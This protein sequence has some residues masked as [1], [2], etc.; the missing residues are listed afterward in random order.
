MHKILFIISIIYSFIGLSQEVFP[1][2]DN[3]GYMR[4]F[5][6]GKAVQIEYLAPR[7]VKYSEKIIAFIDNKRDFFVFDGEEKEFLASIVNGYDIGYNL[8]AW[9]TG[10]ILSVWDSGK[11]KEL[12][13]FGRHY[14]VTD[15]LVVFEDLRDNAIRVYYKDSIYDLFYSVD[16]PVFPQAVGSNSVA[17]VGNGNIH[18]AFIA[19]KIIEIGVINDKVTYSAGANKIAFNDPFNQSFACVHP[20]EIVDLESIM[21]QDYKAGWDIVAYRDL[22]DQLMLY[23]NNTVIELSN[24]S[25]RNYKVFRDMVVWNEA[26]LLFVYDGKLKKKFEVANYI[27]EDYKIR[28]GIVAFRNLNGGVSVYDNGEIKVISNLQNA[29]FEVNGNTVRVKVNRGNF[30]FYQ[31]GKVWNK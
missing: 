29:P 16:P 17:F 13:R 30:D 10:P 19:G 6:D 8:C 24:Y 25:A 1:Y 2:V 3:I 27:P 20:T 5:Q 9:N 28:E 14:Q 15:S 31:N 18:Y 26:G 12:T 11:K 7:D 23:E 21:I 22:N 4:S